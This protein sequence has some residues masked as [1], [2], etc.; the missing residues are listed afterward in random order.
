MSNTT[1]GEAQAWCTRSK[2]EL[3]NS[4]DGELETQISSVV[5]AKIGTTYDVSTWVT[6]L[7]TPKIVRTIIA[8]YYAAWMYDKLF[9]DDNGDANQYAEKL[10]AA[11]D[12]MLSNILDGTTEIPGVIPTTDSGAPSFYP[13]DESSAMPATVED[14]S[15][16]PAWFSMGT[17]F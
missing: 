12:D 4:L 6:A 2:L 16:G 11:A 15:L 14:P 8:M 13:T 7:T 5:L 10:R 1:V 3:G 17:I 9:S